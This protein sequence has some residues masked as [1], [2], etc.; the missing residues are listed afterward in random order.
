MV[1]STKDWSPD[2]GFVTP[3][4]KVT[5]YKVEEQFSS[6]MAHVSSSGESVVWESAQQAS[7]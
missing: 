5:R 2:N 4:L 3:T 1:I 7:I 6:L